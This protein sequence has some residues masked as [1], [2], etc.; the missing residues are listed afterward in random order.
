VRSRF[1]P[2]IKFP[3]LRATHKHKTSKSEL[4]LKSSV[5]RGREEQPIANMAAAEQNIFKTYHAKE[6]YGP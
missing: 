2:N 3:T 4:A 6:E 5:H 1:K